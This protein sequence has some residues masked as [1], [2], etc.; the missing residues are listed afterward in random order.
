MIT[1]THKRGMEFHA[2]INPYRAVFN[3][4]RSSVAPSHITR[5]KPDWFF[6]YG[7]TKY[8]D[9][10]IPDGQQFV[11]NVVRD[12]VKRYE[13]DAIHMDDYFYPYRIG[14]KI[15]LMKILSEI[16]KGFDER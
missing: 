10:G 9:P 7:T 8:F 5:I 6:T 13:I 11:V 1:E 2:W 4:N 12:I 16:W 15:F 3:V 14:T